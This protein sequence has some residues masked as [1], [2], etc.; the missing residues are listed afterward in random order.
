MIM[1]LRLILSVCAA[2]AFVGIVGLSR[3]QVATA[4]AE[5]SAARAET[6]AIKT[7]LEVQSS[8]VRLWKQQALERRERARSASREADALRRK[9]DL[10][11][12]RLAAYNPFGK[13]ECDAMRDLVDLARDGK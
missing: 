4:R 5:T 11:T 6:A 2:I 3:Y 7:D 12:A 9:A 1:D 13:D 10:A 8:A